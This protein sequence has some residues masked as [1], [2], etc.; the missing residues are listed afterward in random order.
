M[1]KGGVLV[2]P[3]IEQRIHKLIEL[4]ESELNDEISRTRRIVVEGQRHLVAVRKALVLKRRQ[5]RRKA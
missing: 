4:P 3:H 1:A 2:K 5:N